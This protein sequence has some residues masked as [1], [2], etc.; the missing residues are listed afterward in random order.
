MNGATEENEP[1]AR[2]KNAD[3]LN[4]SQ[5][6]RDYQRKHKG[7]GVEDVIRGLRSE[8]IT[9]NRGLVYNVRAND[10][11]KKAKRRAAK[12]T[13]ASNGAAGATKADQIREVAGTMS[14]PIRTRDVVAELAARGVVVPGSQVSQVLARAG[15][16]RKRR[17]KT[18]AGDVA[19]SAA[20]D[21]GLNIDDL[22]AAKKLVGQ[23][24]SIERVREA[25]AALAR[26]G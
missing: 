25:L 5:A 3:G 7:A 19:S 24:G 20:S 14:K 26:L 16:K 21:S 6:I 4:R 9:V 15:L 23:V 10:A 13:A 12:D 22:V 11:K 2:T 18:K 8:G 17:R 1:M